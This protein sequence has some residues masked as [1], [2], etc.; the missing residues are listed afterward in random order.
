MNAFMP[1]TYDFGMVAGSFAIAMLASYVTFDLARRVQT[2][3][4]TISLAWWAAGSIVMGT[5]IWAMHFLGMLAFQLPIAV[6]FSGGLTFTSWLAAAVASAVALELA[7][8]PSIDNPRLAL[9]A[10]VVGGGISAM[11]YLGMAAM[12]MTPGIVW[13]PKLVALSFVV[14]IFTSALALSI[15][16]ILRTVEPSRRMAHQIAASLVLALAICGMHYSGMA[17]ASFAVGSVCLSADG[18]GGPGLQTLVL[19]VAGV[20]LVIT[21]LTSILDVRLQHAAKGL[22]ESLRKATSSCKQRMRNC[23][24]GHLQTRSQ[25]CQTDCCSR[26]V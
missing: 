22:T 23:D 26:I 14:A 21:L 11:H 2:H 13:N 8:R 20:L 3:E 5:G 6:G 15:F 19:M 9:G 12:D 16:K 17:A 24:S 18:L 10:L 4:R 7:S 1:F 25:T